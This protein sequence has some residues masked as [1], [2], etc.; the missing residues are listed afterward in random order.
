M[1][2]KYTK[3]FLAARKSNNFAYFYLL[4][5][6]NTVFSVHFT[7]KIISFKFQVAVKCIREYQRI[8][9]CINIV[10]VHF[11]KNVSQNVEHKQ[12]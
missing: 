9:Y 8:R 1:E 3:T 6:R 11:V 10:A 2:K 4:F 12:K 7:F 5:V